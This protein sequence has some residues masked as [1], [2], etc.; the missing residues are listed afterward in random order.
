MAFEDL[1][2]DT[3]HIQDQAK[4]YIEN[5]LAY[6]KLRSFKIMMKS[7][8]SLLQVGIVFSF[9]LV[10]M[11]LGSIAV[12]F[13]LSD[14]FGSYAL[15]FLTVAFCYLLICV[16]VLIFKRKLIERPLLKIFSAIFFND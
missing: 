12:A 2:E 1:K 10:F 11:L 6:F 13:V 4:S 14:C 8:I 15:G 16:L 5:N 3:N 7:L 9:F